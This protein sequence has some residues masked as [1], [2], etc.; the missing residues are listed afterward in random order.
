MKTKGWERCIKPEK[1]HVCGVLLYELS[2]DQAL[3][4][5]LKRGETSGRSDDNLESIRKRFETYERETVPVLQHYQ[6]IV[7]R[8][9]AD[10]SV[11]EV[12]QATLELFNLRFE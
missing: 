5:L 8:I 10:S 1:V 3:P 4:R 12:F 6:D 11:D 9:S 2:L 7:Y